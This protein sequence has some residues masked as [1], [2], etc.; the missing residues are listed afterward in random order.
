[1]KTLDEAMQFVRDEEAAEG[2][3]AKELAHALD[4]GNDVDKYRHLMRYAEAKRRTQ[5]AIIVAASYAIDH[6]SGL[7]VVR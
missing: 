1:M 4:V 5:S 3:C 6:S 7:V 2:R